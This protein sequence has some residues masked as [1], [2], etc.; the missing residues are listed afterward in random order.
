M[1]NLHLH[2]RVPRSQWLQQRPLTCVWRTGFILVINWNW[3]KDKRHRVIVCFHSC[4]NTSCGSQSFIRCILNMHDSKRKTL[5]MNI[6]P[7]STLGSLVAKE[8]ALR[9]ASTGSVTTIDA[10]SH[11]H[12]SGPHSLPL[13][14]R[15]W[16]FTGRAEG[17]SVPPSAQMSHHA[18]NVQALAIGLGALPLAWGAR[19]AGWPRSSPSCSPVTPS[20]AHPVSQAGGVNVPNEGGWGCSRAP[21]CGHSCAA[22][23]PATPWLKMTHPGQ[24]RGLRWWSLL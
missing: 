8:Q 22:S 13:W 5:N 3:N 24:R 16:R 10:L 12:A 11:V 14:E 6:N 9:W 7:S 1:G 17:G 19:G 18:G 4:S 15:R 20:L 2:E 21:W 23:A